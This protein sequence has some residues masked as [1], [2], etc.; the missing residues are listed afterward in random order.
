MH[1]QFILI[2]CI[3]CTCYQLSFRCWVNMYMC[4]ILVL[5]GQRFLFTLTFTIRV[6]LLLISTWK[7]LSLCHFNAVLKHNF[8]RTLS[9]QYPFYRWAKHH[10]ISRLQLADNLNQFRFNINKLQRI[11]MDTIVQHRITFKLNWYT[12][13]ICTHLNALYY[14]KHLHTYIYNCNY[15]CNM[16][17]ANYLNLHSTYFVILPIIQSFNV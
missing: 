5:R 16:H 4:S 17:Y 14:A 10:F 9:F 13:Y 2:I 8:K 15:S 12:K 7:R 3:K 1:F 6:Y 11:I